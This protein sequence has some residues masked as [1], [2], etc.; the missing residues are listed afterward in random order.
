MLA[1]R[2][3]D[4]IEGRKPN[5]LCDSCIAVEVRSSTSAVSQVTSVL[6]LTNDFTRVPANCPACGEQ[7]PLIK[8]G[9]TE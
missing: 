5:A 1:K 9:G 2:I 7:R 3:F 8:A 6:G 4:Y